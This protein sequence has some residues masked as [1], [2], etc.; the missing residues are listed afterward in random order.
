[1]GKGYTAQAIKLLSS[2]AY[3]FLGIKTL[4]AGYSNNMGSYRAFISRGG[5][6][7]VPFLPIGM[8]NMAWSR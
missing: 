8:M 4:T 1:M 2:S 7:M 3:S 6:T 5:R